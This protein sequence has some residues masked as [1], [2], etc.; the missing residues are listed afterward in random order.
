[1][2]YKKILFIIINKMSYY[3]CKRCFY[4]CKLRIDMVRHI[5]KKK[6]CTR[7]IM[8]YQK[9]LINLSCEELDNLSLTKQDNLNL[10]ENNNDIKILKNNNIICE[11]CNK[12]FSKKSNLQRHLIKSCKVLNSK[13]DL[14]ITNNITNISNI[15]N[16]IS[17]NISNNNTIIINI[18]LN[19]PLA[20]DEDWDVSKIDIN[21]KML[22]FL[23]KMKYT[24]TLEE[25]LENEIN[26]NVILE[27]KS[28]IGIVYKNE[29]DNL[30][31]ISIEELV[32]L[33]MEK[34][35]KQLIIFHEETLKNNNYLF[36]TNTINKEKEIL[37]NKLDE[38]KKNKDIKEIVQKMI[39]NIY[40]N[41]KK[42]TEKVCQELLEDYNKEII[43]ESNEDG[44]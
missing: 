3:E 44:Y 35:H 18:N 30:K 2:E 29:T 25:I 12:I 1:M 19:K 34:L 24:K 9:N 21:K 15:L 31:K 10:I 14:N 26:L 36:E 17:N 16:N 28:N 40:C 11:N 33:T 23:S 6:K 43:K 4:K 8:S 13:Q 7:D 37:D 27:N 39:T 20:F 5:N 22:L 42:D 38:F 41:K 32:D